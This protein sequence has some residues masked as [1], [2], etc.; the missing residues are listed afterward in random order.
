MRNDGEIAWPQG[1][2]LVQTSGDD[3]QAKIV[4][5]RNE[6]AAGETFEFSV[7]CQAPEKE[8]RYTAFFRLQT[9]RIKFGHKISCDILCVHPVAAAP[10]EP[11]SAFD[12]VK[13]QPAIAQLIDQPVEM[14]A[15]D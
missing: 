12:D 6:V 1:T 9:G 14:V 3:M 15:Q 4:T 13:M 8:G 7:Q 11:V 2:Q 10:E 5:L